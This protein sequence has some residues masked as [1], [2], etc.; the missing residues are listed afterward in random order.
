MNARTM[1]D[2]EHRRDSS[3]VDRDDN[4]LAD[5]EQ[6]ESGASTMEDDGPT[7][8]L[9]VVDEAI[10]A[11]TIT[12]RAEIEALTVALAQAQGEIYGWR[13]QY[14]E[15]SEHLQQ[16]VRDLRQAEAERDAMRTATEGK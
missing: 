6:A 12:F 9:A 15:T 4:V 11:A 8:Y 1:T 7:S 5:H 14:I 10:A 3:C 13:Q 2:Q 16:R